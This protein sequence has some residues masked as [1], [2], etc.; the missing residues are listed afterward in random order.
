MGTQIV[1]KKK[2]EEQNGELKVRK[3]IG[4]GCLVG[5]CSMFALLSA[6]M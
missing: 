5:I 1:M 2:K 4:T 3:V 6:I